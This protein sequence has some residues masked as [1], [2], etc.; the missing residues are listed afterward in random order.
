MRFG[1][2][3]V[4]E[5]W[6]ERASENRT[7]RP[8]KVTTAGSDF[9]KQFCSKLTVMLVAISAVGLAQ[10]PPKAPTP[11]PSSQPVSSPPATVAGQPAAPLPDPSSNTGGPIDPQ[12]YVIG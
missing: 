1:A 2:F 4:Q 12:R 7:D 9:M 5:A 6:I 8:R 3:K 10:A 11:A